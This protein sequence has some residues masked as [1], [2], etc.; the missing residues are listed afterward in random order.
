MAD[1]RSKPEETVT[2]LRQIEVLAGK[3]VP[4]L[5]NVRS[6]ERQSQPSRC[7]QKVP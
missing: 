4:P 2:K 6:I 1:K 3:E 5:P 7:D